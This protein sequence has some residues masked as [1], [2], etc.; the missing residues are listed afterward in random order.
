MA[1]SEP[2]TRRASSKSNSPI[3][4][5]HTSEA[6]KA[7]AGRLCRL[8]FGTDTWLD[9]WQVKIGRLEDQYAGHVDLDSR[10]LWVDRRHIWSDLTLLH[11]LCH[12]RAGS[13]D[14]DDQWLAYMREAEFRLRVAGD[15]AGADHVAQNAAAEFGT[16]GPASDPVVE[17]LVLNSFGRPVG[18]SRRS[19]RRSAAAV[20]VRRARRTS[21]RGGR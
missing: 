21:T 20:R 17:Q 4:I 11:L 18:S 10:I 1:P 7:A 13:K 15:D 8:L 14:H 12:A 2:S 3:P 19:A 5:R 9:P 6:L 16:T